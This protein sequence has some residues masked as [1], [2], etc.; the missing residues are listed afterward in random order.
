MMYVQVG[1]LKTLK[2]EPH[3]NLLCA[4]ENSL[5]FYMQEEPL[6]AFVR[7]TGAEKRNFREL[8]GAG[9]ICT[10]GSCRVV[11]CRTVGIEA[12]FSLFEKKK[13]KHFYL[14]RS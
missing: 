6:S 13:K 10:V 8:L 3:R 9:D 1:V 7:Y 4:G 5:S 14:K 2:N 12:D 11:F